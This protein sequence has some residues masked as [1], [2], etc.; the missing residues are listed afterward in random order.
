MAGE[1]K[2]SQVIN[3]KEVIK[4][5]N[6]TAAALR[7]MDG[8]L[9][10]I[11]ASTREFEQTTK[12]FSGT[13]KEAAVN[14]K[15]LADNTKRLSD[16]EKKQ[17][18][19]KANLQRAIK[20]ERDEARQLAIIN[21]KQAGTIEK[22]IAK[23]KL[24]EISKRKLTSTGKRLR[25]ETLAYNRQIDKNNKVIKEN[26]AKSQGLTNTLK[27]LGKQFLAMTGLAAAGSI[28]VRKLGEVFKTA[29]EDVRLFE[30][31][32]GNVLTLL[33]EAQKIQFEN[34]LSQGAIDIMAEYGLEIEDVNSAL[35][36]AISAGI[37][38]GQAIAFLDKSAR[39]A[40]SGNAELSAVVNGATTVLEVYKGEATSTTD[41][42]NAFFAAQV[43]GKTTVGL[44]A[45]NIGKV[46]STA[47]A[48]DIPVSELFGTFAGL[49]KFL[50]GTE[51][52]TTALV[53]VINA[54][55]KPSEKAKKTFSDLGIETGITA[56]KSSG[57]LNKLLEVAA[58]YEGNNDVLADLIPNIRAFKGIAGLSAETIA[59]IEKNVRDLNDAELS[60]TLVQ[61]AFN[62]KIE[63]AKKESELLGTSWK[64]L[65]LELGGG[66]SIFRRVG[67]FFRNILTKAIEQTTKVAKAFR[68]SIA[69]VFDI[70]RS[71]E[72]K[73]AQK[74]LDT[75]R[76]VAEQVVES[77]ETTTTELTKEEIERQARLAEIRRKA[78]ELATTQRK[79]IILAERDD[80][81]AALTEVEIERDR[82]HL[83]Q[84][85]NMDEVKTKNE[86]LTDKLL[87]EERKRQEVIRETWLLR[88]EVASAGTD[89]IVTLFDR[90]L[91]ALDK[92][93]QR[94][95]EI[96]G[97]NES[98]REEIELKFEKKQ[99]EIR[100]RQAI[101][102]K[103]SALFGIGVNTALAIAKSLPNLVLAGLSAALGA[104]QAATV[105][106]KPI[107]Q[108]YKGVKDFTGGAAD[109]GERGRELID[110][111]NGTFL[112]P[113]QRT[114]MY[115]PPGTNVIPNPETEKIIN[116]TEGSDDVKELSA[117]NRQLARSIANRPENHTHLTEGG[118]RYLQKKGNSTTEYMDKYI[119]K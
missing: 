82:L 85:A 51:E 77:S 9:T 38:A 21:D 72:N 15:K 118:L 48:A 62:E 20:K 111:P 16:A 107:P 31:T 119:R 94:E 3:E 4:A 92:Q 108:F 27:T 34:I 106:A 68:V 36:D 40:I 105:A 117:S 50:D 98:K 29:A 63:T 74:I 113:D 33:D 81:F 55:I 116:E 2:K 26:R 70:F 7:N 56:V 8:E 114:R 101:A 17:I 69:A 10:K 66:E 80:T 11:T 35:F 79:N 61:E 102:D 46:A 22:L 115:L 13:Q 84:L 93:K 95:L 54:I 37:P 19:I 64:A 25:A 103:L 18:Q 30:E 100:R 49:T 76:G 75:Y 5:L 97:D 60:T 71:E 24:L 67:G 110:T 83:K 39:L 89:F 45:S 90:Q 41:V 44:L 32:F 12:K 52:S 57:L 109:V 43:K 78:A 53:N 87:E 1:I 6:D 99:I 14:Q 73:K 86:E 96:A 91:Q 42:L 112:S 88:A 65:V 104:L 28:I 59:E 47:K 23:N 58:A